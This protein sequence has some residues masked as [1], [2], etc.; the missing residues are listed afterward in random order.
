[1]DNWES[2]WTDWLSL[3][4]E[5]T[6]S[7]DMPILIHEVTA[8]VQALENAIA[9]D[10]AILARFGCV[11]LSWFMECLEDKVGDSKGEG[12]VSL[13]SGRGCASVAM[14]LYISSQGSASDGPLLR[15]RLHERKRIGRR[16]RM[17]IKTSPLLLLIYSESAGA[18]VYVP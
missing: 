9:S 10:S 6:L 7:L 5:T 1:M 14:D 3:L 8:A 2:S 16:W 4:N 12:L 13:G 17:L 15:R 11:Q 18:M